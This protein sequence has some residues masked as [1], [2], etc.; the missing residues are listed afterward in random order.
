LGVLACKSESGG[1]RISHEGAGFAVSLSHA[2]PAPGGSATASLRVVGR[3]GFKINVPYPH[4]QV[5]FSPSGGVDVRTLLDAGAAATN[6]ESELR[7]AVPFQAQSGAGAVGVSVKFSVCNDTEC[8]TPTVA[9]EWK[10]LDHE[11]RAR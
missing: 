10:P 5:T 4:T 2:K 11:T 1:T 8:L 6:T 3:Q 9:F 7:F